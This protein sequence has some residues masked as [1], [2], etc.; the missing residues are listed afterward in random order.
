MAPGTTLYLGHNQSHTFTNDSTGELKWLWF[1]LPGGLEDF[2]EGIGRPRLSGETAPAS[3][4]RP[5][6]VRAI[7]DATVFASERQGQP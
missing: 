7:E 6:N 5:E 3:F 4:A 2:F 1:F